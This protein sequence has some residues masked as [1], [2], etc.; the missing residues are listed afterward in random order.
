MA[1]LV[2]TATALADTLEARLPSVRPRK[3]ARPRGLSKRDVV[4]LQQL[5]RGADDR[6][7]ARAMVL[8]PETASSQVRR[9]LERIGAQTRAGALGY[10]LEQ[11]LVAQEQLPGAPQARP[12]PIVVILF[13]DLVGSTSL[14]ERIGDQQAREVLRAHDKIAREWLDRCEGTEVKHTG[15]G[16]MTSFTSVGRALECA[17]GMQRAFAAYNAQHPERPIDVRMGVNAGEP[18]AEDGELFGTAVNAAAR[19]C[20]H[21]EAGQVLVSDVVRH[22]AQG[23]DVAFVDRGRVPLRGF[24]RRFRLFAVPW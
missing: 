10:A 23:S 1:P 9:L 21:A 17:I 5:A 3:A 8:K 11:G 15:D 20:A 6:A 18:V 4:M 22:L 14:F 12:H 24:K 2:R 13:T 7:I 19:I 16:M